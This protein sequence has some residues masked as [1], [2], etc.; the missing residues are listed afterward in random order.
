MISAARRRLQARGIANVR[1]LVG[2]ALEALDRSGPLDLVF[3]S[4]VLGYIPLS[5]FFASVGHQLSAGGRLAFVVHRE[6]SPREPLEIF[7]ELVARNPAVLRK[8]V[9]FDFPRDK[10]HVETEMTAAG[11]DVESVRE[12]AIV[13]R[14]QSAEQVLEHLLKSGA[15]TVFYDAIDADHRGRL[16]QEFLEML[17]MRRQCPRGYEVR[18]DYVTCIARKR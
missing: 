13:F 18:H 3:T 8:R 11:L 5:P 4:W 12:G 16:T 10:R 7:A 9:S 6:N 2:D 17:A 14:F 15:G 1:W